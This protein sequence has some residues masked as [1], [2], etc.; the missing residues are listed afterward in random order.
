MSEARRRVLARGEEIARSRSLSPEES[1]AALAPT[2][3]ARKSAT[4]L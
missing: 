1:G 4:R 2:S 3:E